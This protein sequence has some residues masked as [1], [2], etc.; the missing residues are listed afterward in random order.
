[1]NALSENKPQDIAVEN[2]PVPHNPVMDMIRQSIAAN[3]PIEVIRELKDMAKELAADE[4]RR[5]FDEAVS[6]AK[7][8]LEPIVKTKDGHNSKYAD[9]GTI[10][11]Q[12]DP[13]LSKYGL[14]TRHRAGQEGTDITV[15]CILSHKLGHFEETPLTAKAD[16]SGNKNGIQA[17]GSTL[18]YLQRY[19]KLLS[20]GLA[21]SDDNDGRGETI[22]DEQLESLRAL[23]DEVGADLE[24]F[25]QYFRIEALP[26]L[27]VS[28]FNRAMESLRAKRAKQ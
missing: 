11:R 13:I 4:A 12:V 18:T 14:S 21:T 15:T 22:N 2:H 16:T 10:D 7:A 24:K 6:Y 1:M 5:A 9:L 25:C 27:P 19:T 3:Q 28:D 26:S 17:I 8:E 20:V 23:A